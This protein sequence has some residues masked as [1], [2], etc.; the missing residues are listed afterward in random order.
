M[1]DTFLL[2]GVGAKLGGVS[3]KHRESLRSCDA[4]HLSLG[5]LLINR[6]SLITLFTLVGCHIDIEVMH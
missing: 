5:D 3:N 2:G 4:S 1:R 6:P